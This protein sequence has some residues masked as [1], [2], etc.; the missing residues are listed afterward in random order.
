V[1]GLPLLAAVALAQTAGASR[2]TGSA[3]IVYRGTLKITV[4]YWGYDCQLRDLLLHRQKTR[5]YRL[6]VRV[7]RNAPAND[8]SNPFNLV[9]SSDVSREAGITLVSATVVANPQDGQRT[10]F[11]YWKLT[12][13][14]TKLSGRLKNS[15]RQAG[16]A[17]NVFPTDRLIVPCR[18]DLG[19]LPRS[20]QPVKE[21]AMLTGTVNA[22]RAALTI[23]GR[24]LDSERRFVARIVA[25]R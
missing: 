21:G 12:R 4:A 6:P 25:T 19:T 22:R 2:S 10:L 14:G 24:T 23:T 11:E 5:A 3:E 20:L 18:P 8:G 17:Q 15:W 16:I 13:R 7:I 9:V 1:L